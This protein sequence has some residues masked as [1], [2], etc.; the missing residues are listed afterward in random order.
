M[1]IFFE[2]LNILFSTCYQRRR[3]DAE[4][5]AIPFFSHLGSDSDSLDLDDDDYL[6]V[7][8]RRRN[9]DFAVH[10]SD[11]ASYS[12]S[13]HFPSLRPNSSLSPENLT[14][15]CL[16]LPY[17]HSTFNFVGFYPLFFFS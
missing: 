3:K 12:D 14:S 5:K 6:A 16:R 7:E 15:T 1:Y 8:W 2:S 9:L 10:R 13:V 17:A 4:G 11:W